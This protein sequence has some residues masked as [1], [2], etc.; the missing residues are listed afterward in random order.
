METTVAP[1]SIAWQLTRMMQR[2]RHRTPPRLENQYTRRQTS[3]YRQQRGDAANGRSRSGVAFVVQGCALRLL[4]GAWGEKLRV[5]FESSRSG[6]ARFRTCGQQY[7]CL[8]REKLMLNSD[9]GMKLRSSKNLD[10][11]SPV[12]LPERMSTALQNRRTDTL[13]AIIDAK[14]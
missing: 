9:I 4:R 6:H 13:K 1:I 5:L 14:A 3:E 8:I 10:Q 12:H 2:L 7:E 11:S